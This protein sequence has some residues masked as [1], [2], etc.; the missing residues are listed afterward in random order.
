MQVQCSWCLSESV[1]VVRLGEVVRLPKATGHTGRRML[2]VQR[3]GQGSHHHY[4]AQDVKTLFSPGQL[5]YH[6]PSTTPHRRDRGERSSLKVTCF[7]HVI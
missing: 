3:Q 5:P 2:K 7:V 6:G 1:Q 4:R